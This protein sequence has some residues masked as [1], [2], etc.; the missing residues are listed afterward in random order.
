VRFEDAMPEDPVIAL[1]TNGEPIPPS[2][3]FPALPFIPQ[4]YGWKSARWRPEIEFARG[5]GDGYSD[6]YGYHERGDAWDEER[7]K[8]LSGTHRRHGSTGS[9]PIRTSDASARSNASAFPGSTGRP[10]EGPSLG[11]DHF[12]PDDRNPGTLLASDHGTGRA[13]W[14]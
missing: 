7:F 14:S 5:Y 10:V 6:Q 1:K 13:E 4:L 3:G 8:G 9:A 11:L 2:E 12:A